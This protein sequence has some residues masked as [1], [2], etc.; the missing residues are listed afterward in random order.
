MPSL[1]RNEKAMTKFEK[2]NHQPQ[3]CSKITKH[4]KKD[5]KPYDLLKEKRQAMKLK[6]DIS[7]KQL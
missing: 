5:I 7:L 4:T 6:L 3:H 1:N 2:N